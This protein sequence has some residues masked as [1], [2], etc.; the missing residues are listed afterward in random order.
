MRFTVTYNASAQDE[1]AAIWNDAGDR[2]A[3]ADAA[4]VIDRELAQDAH[5]KGEEYEGNRLFGHFPLVVAY[6][7]SIDDRLVTVLRV[8]R[9]Y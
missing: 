9:L 2:Q 3:V 6:A 5:Q 4:N 7:V 8:V 1:L